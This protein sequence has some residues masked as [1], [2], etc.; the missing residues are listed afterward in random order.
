MNPTLNINTSIKS[1][2]LMQNASPL[3]N[4]SPTSPFN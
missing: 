4:N 1:K 2:D 3:F